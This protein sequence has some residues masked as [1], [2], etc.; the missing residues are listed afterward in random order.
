MAITTKNRAE[1]IQDLV[2]AIKNRDRA[3]ETGFGPVKDI[4]I[5]PVSLVARDIY[6]QIQHVFDIQFLKNAEKMSTE[7]LDLMGESFGIKRK[8]PVRSTGSIFFTTSSRPTSDVTVPAGFPVA[9]SSLVGTKSV[10]S[11]VTTKTATLFAASADAYFNPQ[12]GVFELEVPIRALVP[13]D[14]S[15]VAAGTITTLQRQ[16][17]GLSAAVNKS[18]TTGGKDAETNAEYA[19]RIRLVLLGT[20]R[21]TQGG[22]KRTTLE[23]DRVIDALVVSPGDPLMIRTETVAGAVDVYVLGDEAKIVSQIET[24]DGLDLTFDSEPLIFPAPVASVVGS[25]VGPLVENTHFYVVQ[26]P[27]LDGSQRARN[28]LRWNRGTTGL[29]EIGETITITYVVDNLIAE[30]QAQIENPENALLADVLYRRA[31]EVPVVMEITMKV[32]TDVDQDTLEGKIRSAVRDFINT[33]GLGEDIVPSDL[34]L[35]IRSV[36]GVDFVFLPFDQ[37]SRE[38]GTGSDIIPIE[39]NE[40]ATISDTNIVLT[41]ST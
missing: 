19:R 28:V 23:D 25:V 35:V 14:A 39:K 7:E 29:P 41:L 31:T 22:L 34:D 30:L 32:T 26:D 4:V 24:Y 5:D 18:A 10:Q 15:R 40:Y 17:P 36:P 12:A 21:G 6:T 11:F 8:G 37:L 38:D 16:I 20:D 1:L 13:G 9:T 3:I 2:N 27:V 33:R